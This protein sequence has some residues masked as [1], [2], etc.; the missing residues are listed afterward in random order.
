MKK[1][2]LLIFILVMFLTYTVNANNNLEL[3]CTTPKILEDGYTNC[4]IM[5]T[6]DTPVSMVEFNYESDMLLTFT[7]GASANLDVTNDKV[8]LTYTDTF[9]PKNI[10]ILNVKIVNND[11][12][13]GNKKVSLKNVRVTSNDVSYSLNNQEQDIA[14]V[15]S[16]DLSSNC[17]LNKLTIDGID[18]TGF[19]PSKYNYNKI[20]TNNRVVFLDAIRSD[21]LS[22][23]TGLGNVLLKE[24][25]E[26]EVNVTVTAENGSK[27]I[28]KLGI[29]YVK[30]DIV[31]SNVDK[32]V[33]SNNNNLDNIELFYQDE[34]I[35]YTFDVKKNNYDINVENKVN[36]LSIKA[37]LQDEKASFVS[38]F[39]PR[40]V[41]LNEGKNTFLIK[42]EALNGDI[43]TYTLNII[44][45]K[46]KSG[47]ITLKSLI[48][49]DVEVELK[50]NE[51]D[52]EINLPD[53]Y[54]ETD[55]S[56]VANDNNSKI[57]YKNINLTDENKVLIKVEAENGD[58]GEYNITVNQ[59]E[60]VEKE[61]KTILPFE[62]IEVV[63]YDL[64]F[65]INKSE[66]ELKIAS[67]VTSLDFKVVPE[68]IDVTILNNINLRDGSIVT[69]KVIDGVIERSYQIKIIKDASMNTN[70]LCYLFFIS[71]I[72]ILLVSFWYRVK[73]KK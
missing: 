35:N 69:V 59:E 63:G 55:I 33:V 36:T 34:K 67:D 22:S 70:I 51:F 15:S 39:G 44:R 20:V 66:Y 10:K 17:N 57:T 38:K 42:V 72:I 29:T 37:I 4:D 73:I 7:K 52:Y 14:I 9:I 13:V 18:V 56:A 26:K 60:K 65:D 61:E 71:A 68:N 46:T 16:N 27:C 3:V 2:K 19:S 30:K 47:D 58:V 5:L 62:K 12:Q 43:K 41:N 48:I 32:E 40:N 28:Y 11:N 31:E 21:E 64:K 24:N 1:L 54:D 6:Y 8:V 25:E 50:S 53:I 45:D 23:V 49:N